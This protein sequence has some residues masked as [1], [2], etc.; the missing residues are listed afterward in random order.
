[1]LILRNEDLVEMLTM[2]AA[3]DALQRMLSDQAARTIALPQRSMLDVDNG[4]LLRLMPVAHNARGIMGFKALNHVP[5]IGTRSFV[6][7]MNLTSGEVIALIDAKYIT[8]LRTS[9]L[10]AIAT[11]LFAPEAIEAMALLGS[12]SLAEAVLNAIFSIRTI[13]YV[14]VYSPT[15]AHRTEFARS[16]SAKLGI[17]VRAVDSPQAAI[18]PANLVCGAF[19]AGLTPVIEAIDLRP[20]AHVNSVSSVGPNAREVAADVWRMCSSVCVDHRD[21]VAQ[22]GD[23]ASVLRDHPFDLERAPELWEVVRDGRCRSPHDGVTMFKSVGAATQDI[24]L[25]MLAYDI[26]ADRGMGEQIAD[27]PSLRVPR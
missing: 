24:A 1:M 25:A 23:G 12:G 11:N 18:R 10:V 22:S 15:P 21:A 20:D 8:T 17:D 5:D 26:A 3:I 6:C 7:L 14:S 13:P 27:F 2:N 16:M 9:A 19:R 4:S